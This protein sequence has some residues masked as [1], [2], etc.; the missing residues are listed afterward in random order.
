MQEEKNQKADVY[1]N[2]PKIKDKQILE[3]S[4]KQKIRLF[5]PFKKV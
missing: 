4:L 1:P 2:P 3:K 5:L